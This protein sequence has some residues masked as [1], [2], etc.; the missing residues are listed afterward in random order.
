[1]D[2]NNE[3]KSEKKVDV[4]VK[5]LK[6]NSTVGTSVKFLREAVIM[7]QFSNDNVVELFGVV[8]DGEPVRQTG[9]PE[10]AVNVM[11]FILLYCF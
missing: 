3:V 8:I 1:M 5:M 11:H 10:T 4:A 9:W 2:S 6:D 7:G